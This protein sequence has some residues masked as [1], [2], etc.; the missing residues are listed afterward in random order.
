MTWLRLDPH[1]YTAQE[2]LE[3][4]DRFKAEKIPFSI[5]VIDMDWH[6]VE[7]VEKKDG[8]GWT[9]EGSSASDLIL[10]RRNMIIL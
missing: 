8:H 9:G 1:Q 2:Y 7:E 10:S 6:L 3:V 4:M 5:G